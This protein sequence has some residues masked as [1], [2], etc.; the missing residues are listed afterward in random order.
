MN[1]ECLCKKRYGKEQEEV[2]KFRDLFISKREGSI[3]CG[4]RTVGGVSKRS[5]IAKLTFN[6][7]GGRRSIFSVMEISYLF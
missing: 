1:R 7:Y 2:D 4:G 5:R 6:I 3:G